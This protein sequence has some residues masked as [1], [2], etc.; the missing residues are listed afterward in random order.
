MAEG[1]TTE[2]SSLLGLPS[3]G[4]RNNQVPVRVTMQSLRG[5][6]HSA[7][8]SRELGLRSPVPGQVDRSGR[9]NWA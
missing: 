8:P 5:R 6:A 4:P 2:P 9:E 3:A 7:H 1:Y